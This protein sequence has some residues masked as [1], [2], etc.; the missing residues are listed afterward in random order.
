[1]RAAAARFFLVSL[2]LGCRAQ[3]LT[4]FRHLAGVAARRGGSPLRKGRANLGQTLGSRSGPDSF[5]LGQ[6][7]VLPLAV[8]AL[9][10][11]RDGN[12]LVI[13]KANLLC[14]FGPLETLSRVHV[15]VLAGNVEVAADVLARPAHRLH[16]IGR[17]LALGQNCLVKRLLEAVAALRHGLGAAGDANLDGVVGNG[18]GN[19]GRRLEPR[20]AEAVNRVGAGRVGEAGGEGGGSELVGSFTIQ[21]LRPRAVSDGRDR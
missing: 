19:V 18:M 13:K 5:V 14:L 7:H 10:L 4:S 1:M 12:N 21:H 20:G 6:S 15:H 17:L 8:R 9:D 3:Q 2:L 16:A 11:G